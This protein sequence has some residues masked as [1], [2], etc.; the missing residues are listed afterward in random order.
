MVDR[1]A[2][3]ALLALTCSACGPSEEMPTDPGSNPAHWE[4]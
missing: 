2:L 1:L 4:T 3:A